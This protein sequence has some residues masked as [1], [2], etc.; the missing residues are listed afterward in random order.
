MVMCTTRHYN[1]MMTA[2]DEILEHDS[3]PDW[4]MSCTEICANIRPNDLDGDLLEKTLYFETHI[5]NVLR[6][7]QH[8]RT[9]IRP[10]LV[11][12]H[13]ACGQCLAEMDR[14]SDAILDFEEEAMVVKFGHGYDL[15]KT[16]ITL[17]GFVYTITCI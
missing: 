2:Y 1:G 3:D 8:A 16:S 14:L 15:S 9:H 4:A 13:V 6:S 17:R 7:Y 11:S 12:A 5:I 10:L